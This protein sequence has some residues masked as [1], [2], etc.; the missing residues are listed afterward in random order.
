VFVVP[1][2]TSAWV[3]PSIDTENRAHAPFSSRP[4]DLFVHPAKAPAVSEKTERE[5]ADK[6]RGDVGRPLGASLA[7]LR[8]LI[9]SWFLSMLGHSPFKGCC[10][11][12]ARGFLQHFSRTL[13]TGLYIVF[14]WQDFSTSVKRSTQTP[15]RTH[16]RECTDQSLCLLERQSR[17]LLVASKCAPFVYRG[18]PVR[19]LGA[20]PQQ[21][22]Q[23]CKEPG[24]STPVRVLRRQS[25]LLASRVCLERTCRRIQTR[26][27]STPCSRRC[28]SLCL[29]PRPETGRVRSNAGFSLCGP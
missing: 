25:R 4:L 15:A 11:L 17:I 26:A 7:D 20:G 22:K 12:W 6:G 13:K 19:P 29:A 18:Q 23:K 10:S 28:D 9:G 5:R 1:S 16:T 24:G 21:V 2:L 8:I 3:D 27:E 14:G